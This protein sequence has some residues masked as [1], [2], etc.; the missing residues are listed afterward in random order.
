MS[1]QFY[2]QSPLGENR[3]NLARKRIHFN[4]GERII[5]NGE[6]KLLRY[7]VHQLSVDFYHL[8]KRILI[9]DTINSLNPHHPAFDT[10]FQS[11]YFDNIYC[12]RTPLPYDLWAR[13]DTASSFIKNKKITVLLITSLS[14]LFKEENILEVQS[15]VFNILKKA[16]SLTKDHNL[17]T[18]I[19]NSPHKDESVM[20]AH[21]ILSN[22]KIVKGVV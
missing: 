12:V 18:I 15:M 14:L 7:M 1:L 11:Q 22:Q 10:P 17:I 16:D 13:L 4:K 3:S 2:H 21:D 6:R 9:I 5:L 20:V 8:G 19:A